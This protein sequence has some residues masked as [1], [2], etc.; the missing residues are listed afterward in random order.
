MNIVQRLISIA[1]GVSLVDENAEK[2]KKMK[3][4]YPFKDGSTYF[5]LNDEGEW[6]TDNGRKVTP[7]EYR[8]YLEHT[9]REGRAHIESVERS[10]KEKGRKYEVD[11]SQHNF[12]SGSQQTDYNDLK[13]IKQ[14][15]LNIFQWHEF[16]KRAGE[17]LGILDETDPPEEFDK[18][19]EPI[20]NKLKEIMVEVKLV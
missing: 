3:F 1:N 2:E 12:F 7:S 8:N 15:G 11:P 17:I 4:K 20:M 6:I 19:Y 18:M 9:D 10:Y 16:K 14:L 5:Y 13:Y